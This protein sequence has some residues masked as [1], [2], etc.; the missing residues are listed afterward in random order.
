MDDKKQDKL[1]AKKIES[2]KSAIKQIKNI[3][4]YA[5]VL[6]EKSVW[7][8]LEKINDI[9]F[10][11]IQIFHSLNSM[12]RNNNK[13]QLFILHSSLSHILRK[14]ILSKLFFYAYQNQDCMHCIFPVYQVKVFFLMF[15]QISYLH[16]F[17]LINLRS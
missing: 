15:S 14:S 13:S 4:I 9:D 1:Y 17:T 6:T 16:L 10:R 12:V 5:Y 7:I 3:D 8:E 11:E 2:F